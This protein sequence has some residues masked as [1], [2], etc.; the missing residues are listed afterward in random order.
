M[1]VCL[2]SIR[3]ALLASSFAIFKCLFW[4]PENQITAVEIFFATGA[5]IAVPPSGTIFNELSDL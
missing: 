5:T 4:S 1:M 2:L 3:N